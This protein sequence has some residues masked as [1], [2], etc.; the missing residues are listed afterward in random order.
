MPPEPAILSWRDA[1]KKRE[2][3]NRGTF[4]S[5]KGTSRTRSQ[6]DEEDETSRPLPLV[7]ATPWLVNSCSLTWLAATTRSPAFHCIP[8]RTDFVR[9]LVGRD[10]NTNGEHRGQLFPARG[11]DLPTTS[12]G[13]GI[14]AR[15]LTNSIST[16]LHSIS[17]PFGLRHVV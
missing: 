4:W 13:S 9:C 3:S 1:T 6:A 8:R 12:T 2:T 10:R 7:M 11:H 14:N 5:N 16:P 15:V 17:L